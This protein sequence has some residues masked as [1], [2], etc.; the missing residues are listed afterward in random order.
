M[1]KARRLLTLYLICYFKLFSLTVLLFLIYSLDFPYK[2]YIN[3]QVKEQ[4]NQKN[5]VDITFAIH[6]CRQ[7]TQQEGDKC[8]IVHVEDHVDSHLVE[9]HKSLTTSVTKHQLA[10][11]APRV[12]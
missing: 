1:C 2:Y 3:E 7:F 5:N 9:R 12:N 4:T 6:F 11:I 8:A 10:W